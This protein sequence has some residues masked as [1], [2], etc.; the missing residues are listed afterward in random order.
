MSLF[1]LHPL[2]ISQ[3]R[4]TASQK[5]DIQAETAAQP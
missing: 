3:R 2:A 4:V 1:H 5:R